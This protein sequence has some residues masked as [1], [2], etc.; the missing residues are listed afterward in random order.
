MSEDRI[1]RRTAALAVRI[2]KAREAGTD[3][4][5]APDVRYARKL[6]KRAQRRAT[7]EAKRLA[8]V[9]A[10]APKS[11]PQPE[12]ARED[13][14]FEYADHF[15]P[16]VTDAGVFRLP[17]PMTTV[18]I[19]TAVMGAAYVSSLIRPIWYDARCNRLLADALGVRP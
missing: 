12:P 9:K 10:R 15:E 18:Y 7:R 13:A 5:K 17:A 16:V 14:G 1:A 11:P 19:G 8:R 2:E 4:E 6:V 3:P